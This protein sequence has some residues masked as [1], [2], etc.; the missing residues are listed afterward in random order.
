MPF[1]VS[2]SGAVP[3]PSDSSEAEAAVDRVIE[4]LER[5]G[6]HTTLQ[7]LPDVSISIPMWRGFRWNWD[8][9]ATLDRVDLKII[10]TPH[11]RALRYRLSLLRLVGIGT[12]VLVSMFFLGTRQGF[13]L[14]TSTLLLMW[15]WIIGGNYLW[16][17][18][19]AKRFFRRIVAAATQPVSATIVDPLPG[20]AKTK[21]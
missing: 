18:A 7:Y 10:E 13:S 12:A 11:G 8:I 14:P 2:V 20:S 3:L 4:T 19:R 15:S 17:L 9:A 1:P 16:T 6:G 21:A 5:Q